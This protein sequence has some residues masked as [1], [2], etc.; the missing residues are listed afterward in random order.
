MPDALFDSGSAFDQMKLVL[1][2]WLHDNLENVR[3]LPIAAMGDYAPHF[4]AGWLVEIAHKGERYVLNILL[5]GQFPYTPIRIALRSMDV[6]LKWPHVER[7][8]L[9][10]LPRLSAP[11]TNLDTV[12]RTT[13]GDG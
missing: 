11:V 12:I 10:C 9:L 3:S 8:G 4:V 7:G 5:D 1:T 13:I 6:Y 2:R